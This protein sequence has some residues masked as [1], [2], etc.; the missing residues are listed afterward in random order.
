MALQIRQCTWSKQLNNLWFLHRTTTT[1]TYMNLLL[2]KTCNT[3]LW[4]HIGW[5]LINLLREANASN[6]DP[7]LL[8][9]CKVHK[10][11]VNYEYCCSSLI[12][13]MN[14]LQCLNHM[15]SISVH[16]YWYCKTCEQLTISQTPSSPSLSLLWWWPPLW[17]SADPVGWEGENSFLTFSAVSFSPIW[18]NALMRSFHDAVGVDSSHFRNIVRLH[19]SCLCDCS[20]SMLFN[21]SSS[22]P[23]VSPRVYHCVNWMGTVASSDILGLSSSATGDWRARTK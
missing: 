4:A 1:T 16:S 14:T 6:F 22:S 11:C 12:A 7:L 18:T 9:F 20:T 15:M 23:S 17:R 3:A 2:N 21:T 5:I 10:G 19:F 8:L 13:T